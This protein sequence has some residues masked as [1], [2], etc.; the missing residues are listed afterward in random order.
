[1]ES[2]EI[3]SSD[4]DAFL[5]FAQNFNEDGNKYLNKSELEAAAEA[6]NAQDD[7]ETQ[8]IADEIQ[9]DEFDQWPLCGTHGRPKRLDKHLG[10]SL[11]GIGWC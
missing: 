5:T 1:M 2:N 4:K 11:Q 10:G 7:A 3:E 6:W 9:E 8:D